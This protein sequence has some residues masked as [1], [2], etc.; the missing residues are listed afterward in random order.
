MSYRYYEIRPCV[1]HDDRVTSFLGE[2]QWCQSRGTDVCTPESAYE[3]AKAYAESVGKGADD[4]FWTLY[5]IDEEGLAEAIGDFKT[6]EDAYGVM[7]NILGP[8]REALDYA[9]DDMEQDC[10]NTLTD[11]LLQSTMEDRI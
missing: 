2:P 10:I 7:C 6:F 9:E 8:M 11:V 4:V 1:E 3:Q 5:G